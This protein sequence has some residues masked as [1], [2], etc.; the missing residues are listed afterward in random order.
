MSFLICQCEFNATMDTCPEDDVKAPSMT[1]GKIKIQN[2]MTSCQPSERQ[3]RLSAPMQFQRSLSLHSKMKMM[4]KG[5]EKGNA[6]GK[7]RCWTML[8]LPT[9]MIP[10]HHL[11]LVT[12]TI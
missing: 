2:F 10:E 1:F 4:R 12:R 7:Q 3:E 9:L 6:K 8:N 11:A 5:K